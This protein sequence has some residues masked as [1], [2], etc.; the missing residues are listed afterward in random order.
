M[1][2]GLCELFMACH[3]NNSPKESGTGGGD[4]VKNKVTYFG[5]CYTYVFVLAL[6]YLFEFLNELR[7]HCA[8][9]RLLETS[10][11]NVIRFRKRRIMKKCLSLHFCLLDP[12]IC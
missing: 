11:G 8:I 4:G 12:L 10:I 2:V 5:I 3:K 1:N 7:Q 6:L 9:L